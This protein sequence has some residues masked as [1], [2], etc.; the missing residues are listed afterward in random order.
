VK[1]IIDSPDCCVSTYDAELN[2]KGIIGIESD[3]S[4]VNGETCKQAPSGFNCNLKT[5]T[6]TLLQ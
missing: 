2:L 6:K 5:P 1:R 3:E 4:C